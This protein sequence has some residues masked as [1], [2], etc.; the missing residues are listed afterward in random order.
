MNSPPAPL[1]WRVAGLHMYKGLLRAAAPDT[2]ASSGPSRCR[3]NAD[4]PLRRGAASLLTPATCGGALIATNELPGDAG[5]L[6]HNGSVSVS[7]LR[8]SWSGMLT[9]PVGRELTSGR[10]K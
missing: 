4:P 10:F 9:V 2:D 1:R 3:A 7:H 8:H 6:V 5:P